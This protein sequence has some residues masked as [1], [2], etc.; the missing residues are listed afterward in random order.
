MRMLKS[1]LLTTDF[2]P[3]SQEASKVAV[4]LAK[5]FGSR[6]TLLHVIEPTPNW[7]LAL[8]EESKRGPLQEL[9]AELVAQNV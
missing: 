3:A 4:E 7:P 8:H 9:S 2:R 6:I 5:T 1:I